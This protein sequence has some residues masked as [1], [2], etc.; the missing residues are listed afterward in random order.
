MPR[1]R[2]P[3]RLVIGLG[4]CALF[5]PPATLVTPQQAA[6][7]SPSVPGPHASLVFGDDFHE[8]DWGSRGATW[9]T[10]ST[11]Y[12]NGRTNPENW[13]LDKVTPGAVRLGKGGGVQFRATP[14]TRRPAGAWAAGLLTTEPWGDGSRGGNGFTLRPGDFVLV[15]LRLP[16]RDGGGGHGAWPG[17]WTWKDGGNEVDILEWH[18]ETPDVAEVVNHVGGNAYAWVHSRLL[19]FGRW[20]YVGARLGR[21]TVTWYLG[22]SPAHMRAVFS[23][24]RGVPS[25]WRAYLVVNLSVS[26]QEGRVPDALTPITSE[27]SSVRVYR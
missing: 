26:A 10:Y 24:G 3:R 13:K 16:T 23:D 6:A 8:R 5:L 2:I 27:L 7:H 19:G 11:A 1:Y 4:G 14:V 17:V 18:G 9:S 21:D 20:V 15:H 12:P 22:S 25:D